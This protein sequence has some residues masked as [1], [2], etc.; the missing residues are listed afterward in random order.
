MRSGRSCSRLLSTVSMRPPPPPARRI[1]ELTPLALHWN[2]FACGK[3][4]LLV[5]LTGVRPAP[6]GKV[7]W[8]DRHARAGI[9][10]GVL[11]GGLTGSPHL[12]PHKGE[13]SGCGALQL[14]D[15]WARTWQARASARFCA[16]IGLQ[17]G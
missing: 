9:G 10:P 12:D 7:S 8:R 13:R 17:R 2:Y 1:R 15:R 5:I 6:F 3:V 16:V 4:R 11:T 14:E